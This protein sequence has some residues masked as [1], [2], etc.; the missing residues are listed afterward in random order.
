MSWKVTYE[1]ALIRKEKKTDQK[2]QVQ[3]YCRHIIHAV[4]FNRAA[5]QH[6]QLPPLAWPEVV[7]AKKRSK[8]RASISPCFSP[9]VKQMKLTVSCE[10]LG[11]Y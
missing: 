1:W 9:K 5:A 6:T 10:S 4:I 8:R 2:A 11:K 7:T 3:I